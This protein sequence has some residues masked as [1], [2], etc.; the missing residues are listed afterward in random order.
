DRF[1]AY[2]DMRPSQRSLGKVAERFGVSLR[3]TEEQSVKHQWVERARQYDAHQ[4]VQRRQRNAERD[5]ILSE[6]NM[7]SAVAAAEVTKRSIEY[8]RESGVVLEPG[9]L[10]AWVAMMLDLRRAAMEQPDHVVQ[11]KGSDDEPLQ[12]EVAE[13][14][15][16]TPEAKRQRA[17][18]IVEGVQR[19]YA[20]DGGKT[21]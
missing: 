7:S 6:I 11:L 2:R 10:K 14:A 16:L 13:F 9:D 1:C 18:E 15:G 3:L 20:I 8:V 19:L 17:Q 12:V 21:A 4:D 5:K